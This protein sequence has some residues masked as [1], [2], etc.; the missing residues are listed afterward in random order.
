[1]YISV[2]KIILLFSLSMPIFFS[3]QARPVCLTRELCERMKK[4][5]GLLDL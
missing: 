1:M 3:L 5:N 2:K 4:Y